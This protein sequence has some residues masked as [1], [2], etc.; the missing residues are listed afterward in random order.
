MM[1]MY[2]FLNNIER[3][4][5]VI[6]KYLLQFLLIS[7][8]REFF[9]LSINDVNLIAHSRVVNLDYDFLVPVDKGRK[10]FKITITQIQKLAF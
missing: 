10:F 2:I 9:P 7:L 6:G 5:L 8:S 1:L 3:V 4:F